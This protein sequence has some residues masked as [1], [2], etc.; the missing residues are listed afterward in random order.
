MRYLSY[1]FLVFMCFC[2]I[3]CRSVTQCDDIAEDFYDAV[4]Q[5]NYQKAIKL[6]DNKAFIKRPPEQWQAML[7]RKQAEY[8]LWHGYQRTGFFTKTK[9]GRLEV[10]IKYKVLY[11]HN[12]RLNEEFSFVKEKDEEDFRLVNYTFEKAVF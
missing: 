8:G 12:I 2:G 7:K 10:T 6:F 4:K 1:A 3:S 9:K 11:R 5:E